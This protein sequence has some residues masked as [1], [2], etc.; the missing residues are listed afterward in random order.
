MIKYRIN[1]AFLYFLSLTLI[2]WMIYSINEIQR[3]VTVSSKLIDIL[4]FEGFNNETGHTDY[5]V[6]NI[7]HLLYFGI[8]ELKFYQLI[9]IYSI[10]INHKPDW[11]YIHCDN[12]CSFR[13]TYWQEI[14]AIDD[15]RSRIRLNKIP[16]RSTIFGVK[17]GWINHHRSDV[18]RLLV[19]MNYGGIFLDNDMF[20]INSLNKYRRYEMTV[21]W[22][23]P[24]YGV[25]VQVLIAHRNAR[26]LR[27]HFDAYRLNFPS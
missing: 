15:L 23:G 12:E 9:N 25:G 20:V 1:L 11:I 26:L 3:D 18:W 27:A 8:T 17:Y 5:I 24:E 7:V 14:Q 4:D 13:G 6:P 16:Y 10:Y 2:L 22:D 21:S 19:L